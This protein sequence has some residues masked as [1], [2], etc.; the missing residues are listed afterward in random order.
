MYIVMYCES[1][2]FKSSDYDECVDYI[3]KYEKNDLD[4]W[5]LLG[6]NGRCISF[7]L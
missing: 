7:V 2:V 4:Y 6:P 5:D 3:R 1:E